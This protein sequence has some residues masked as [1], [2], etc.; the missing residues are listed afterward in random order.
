MK[1]FILI[2]LLIFTACG[3][4]SAQAKYDLVCE[5]GAHGK[6]ELAAVR[7]NGKWGFIDGSGKEIVKPQYD[8]ITE[9]VTQE[10]P[11][12]AA[13]RSNGKWGFIDS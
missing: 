8:L 11:E 4:V 5:F 7:S 12:C 13:V 2:S 3:Y 6:P 1:K 10:N 9:F